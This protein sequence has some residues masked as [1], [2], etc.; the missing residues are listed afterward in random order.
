[1]ARAPKEQPAPA[2]APKTTNELSDEQRHTLFENNYARYLVLS[3]AAKKANKALKDHGKIIKAD[4]GDYGLDMI[5]LR[6]KIEGDESEAAVTSAKDQVINMLRVMRWAGLP[7]GHTDDIFENFDNRPLEEQAEDAG[8]IAGMR[9]E[10]MKAPDRW[11]TGDLFQAWCKGWNKGQEQLFD[12]R[13]T[14]AKP[15]SG[16]AH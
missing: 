11:A 13:P 1:M 5:K 15:E 2:G 16:T 8:K 6:A 4:L 7:I 12:I 14:A 3:E 10:P 9:G